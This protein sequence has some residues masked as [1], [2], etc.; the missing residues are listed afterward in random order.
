MIFDRRQRLRRERLDFGIL[1]GRRFHAE[2]ADVLLVVGQPSRE[3][4]RLQFGWR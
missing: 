4:F 1:A 3:L 2:L